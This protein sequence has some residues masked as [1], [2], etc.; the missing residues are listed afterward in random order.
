MKERMTSIYAGLRIVLMPALVMHILAFTARAEDWPQF[1]GMHRDGVS[2]E[3]GL[4]DEW[5]AEGPPKL[6]EVDAGAGD[7]LWHTN[8]FD[9]NQSDLRR[10]H[11]RPGYIYADG[12]LSSQCSKGISLVAVDASGSQLVSAFSDDQRGSAYAAPA[13]SNGRLYIRRTNGSLSCYD[14]R[15]DVLSTNPADE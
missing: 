9:P 13:L 7:L 8:T 2:P 6:W 4:L 15:Q 3:A 11:T 5:P 10:H 1:R 14:V 12:K